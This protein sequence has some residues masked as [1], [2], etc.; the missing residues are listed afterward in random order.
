MDYNYSWWLPALDNIEGVILR[1]NDMVAGPG[2]N[3]QIFTDDK[4]SW[5]IYHG[6]L[7]QIHGCREGHKKTLGC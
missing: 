1:G 2:H 6:I 3:A 5:F 7:A 4:G